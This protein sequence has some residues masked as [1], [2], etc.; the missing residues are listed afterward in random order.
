MRVIMFGGSGMVGQGMLRVCEADPDVTEV[1]LV[2][3]QPMATTSAK[4]TE[5]VHADF[6]DWTGVDFSG[7]DACFFCLGVS[8]LGMK[9][10]EY[11]HVTYDLTMAAAEPLQRAG[12]KTFI[13]ISGAHTDANSKQMWAR[14]KGATENALMAMPFEQVFCFRPGFIQ[15][16]P[17]VKSKVPLYNAV[18]VMVAWAYPLIRAVGRKFTVD[19][20]EIGKAML[21]VSR[22]GYPKRVLEVGD[23]QVAAKG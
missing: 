1:L 11:R 18:Y 15:A 20:D 23:I 2:V 3:R 9:E 8:S 6:F 4:V 13:Y 16:A 12:V 19:W 10:P 21:A 22:R 5:L 17:G 7:Y 14:V